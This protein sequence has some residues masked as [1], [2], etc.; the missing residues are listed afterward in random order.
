MPRGIPNGKPVEVAEVVAEAAAEV[1]LEVEA[2]P[3]PKGKARTEKFEAVRPD[4]TVVVVSRN[5]DTG[6][7]TVSKK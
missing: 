3:E 5:I 2:K 7:Q 6:E 1:V 4:G